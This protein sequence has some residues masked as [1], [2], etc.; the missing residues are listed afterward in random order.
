MML[1]DDIQKYTR[2]LHKCANNHLF[3]YDKYTDFEA[4]QKTNNKRWLKRRG[5]GW[6]KTERG[7]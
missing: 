1:Y 2:L 3:G 6:G 5:G 4:V 7:R